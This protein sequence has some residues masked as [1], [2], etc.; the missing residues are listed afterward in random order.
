VAVKA[1]E[2][3]PDATITEDGAVTDVLLLARPTDCPPVPA[4]ASSVTVQV[5]VPAPV[6][7]ALVQFSPLM[8]GSLAD[9]P[10]SVAVPDKTTVS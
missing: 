8:A 1:A 7:D 6:I 3:A 10:D 9:E 2:V 5:S 4:A